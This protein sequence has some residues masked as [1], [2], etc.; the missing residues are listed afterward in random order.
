MK[1][2][3]IW[4]A[5]TLNCFFNA[6][7]LF[8]RQI[9]PFDAMNSD[10][11]GA[12]IASS[13]SF[14]FV[15]SIR[16]QNM[17][18][19][20]VYVFKF[21]NNDYVFKTK[22]FPD[23]PE[24]LALFGS[25]LY[26]KDEQL[27]VGARNKRVNGY[28]TG[29]LYVFKFENG[30]WIQ[31]QKIEPPEPLISHKYFSEA[32]DKLNE[33]LVVSSY[34]SDAGANDNGKVF[35][36]KYINN[37]YLLQQELSAYDP[38]DYQFFGSS[39][40]LKENTLLIGCLNDSTESGS[41]SGSIYAYLKKD[42]NWVFAR[43]FIPHPNPQY[44]TLACSMT[45]NDCFLFAGSAA[46]FSY[47]LPGKVYIYKFSEPLMELHQI[48]ESGEGFWNDRFGINMLA[49][50]DTLLVTAF[51][52]SVNNS[53]PGSVYMFVKENDYWIKKRKIV[54]SDEELANLFGVS[55]AINNEIIFIGA[56]TADDSLG[57]SCGKVY[58]Y[59]TTPLSVFDEGPHLVDEFTLYQNYPNPFNSITTVTYSIPRDGQITIDI[60]NV[61]GQKIKSNH[62]GYKLKGTH[63]QNLDFSDIPSGVY[64][65]RFIANNYTKTIK[66]VLLK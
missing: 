55:L 27:F 34:R 57:I 38:K 6:Q 23:D 60:F 45:A 14:L 62:I 29:A 51:F 20:C 43:K 31:N 3:Y 24:D 21:E 58:L 50:G 42:T 44:L 46:S 10:H 65:I 32:I 15:S 48:I 28:K 35:V 52:D 41:E 53:Y 4:L 63:T 2:F 40:V 25:S 54:P 22:I 5:L 19:G 30:S 17:I 61:L 16:Y 37:N 13:D 39:L 1:V 18:E 33:T 8:E 64:L 36:Y 7:T 56:S 49:K 26:Y 11:F 66:A 9:V 47:N 59:S 12:G